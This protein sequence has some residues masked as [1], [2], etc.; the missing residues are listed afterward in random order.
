M[1]LKPLPVKAV[2]PLRAL[3]VCERFGRVRT[4]L[5]ALGHEAY[6]CDLAD[7][8]EAPTGHHLAEDALPL[9]REPWDLV[10]A[11]PPCTYLAHSGQGW[12]EGGQNTER[13]VKM[14]AAAEFYRAC[15]DANSPRVAVEN[16]KQHGFALALINLPAGFYIQ[17]YMLGDNW[18]KGTYW[19]VRGLPRLRAVTNWTYEDASDELSVLHK[20]DDRA[21]LRSKT[22]W[23]TAYEIARQWAGEVTV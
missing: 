10:I 5:R 12:L 23:G 22:G 19:R 21:M 4:A 16:P 9:L 7:D 11:H 20:S 14:Q 6:S 17:P 13:M 15:Y 1:G 3:V 8:P 2:K 18:R